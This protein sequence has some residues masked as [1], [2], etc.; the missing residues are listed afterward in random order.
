MIS[1]RRAAAPSVET[2]RPGH[3]PYAALRLRD[4]FWGTCIRRARRWSHSKWP[5]GPA[6]RFGPP[7]R[8][9]DYR[10]IKATTC[11]EQRARVGNQTPEKAAQVGP[12]C[13]RTEL[14]RRMLLRRNRCAAS[15]W[16]APRR[17][18]GSFNNGPKKGLQCW[19]VQ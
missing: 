9:G 8:G 18:E 13:V 3:A 17:R 1:A 7:H 6:C 2:A 14:A 16:R 19:G 4:V 5:E 10:S 15:V 12:T 11:G